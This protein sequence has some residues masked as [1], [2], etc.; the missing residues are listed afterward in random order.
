MQWGDVEVSSRWC[1]LANEGGKA[2][3][4]GRGVGAQVGGHV[5]PAAPAVV[6]GGEVGA[7]GHLVRL[8]GP[9]NCGLGGGRDGRGNGPEM[10]RCRPGKDVGGRGGRT[11]RRRATKERRIGRRRMVIYEREDRGG[12][13][14]GPRRGP[15]SEGRWGEEGSWKRGREARPRGGPDAEREHAVRPSSPEVP[16]PRSTKQRTSPWGRPERAAAPRLAPGRPP[17][18]PGGRGEKL[19]RPASGPLWDLL[20][21]RF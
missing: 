3:E 16:P 20:G 1:F 2:C 9:D 14:R 13:G 4:N 19:I 18:G 11:A 15:E 5:I 21:P 12:A 10:L 7:Q 17:G 6:S 8:R